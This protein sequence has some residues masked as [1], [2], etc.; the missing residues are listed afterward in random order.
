MAS[1]RDNVC[2]A[3]VV[4]PQDE[5]DVTTRL[6]VDSR[7][8]NTTLHPNPNK[9]TLTLENDVRDV[10]QLR[11]LWAELPSRT[12][13]LV[14]AGRDTVHYRLASDP[15]DTVREAEMQRGD[16]A[17]P[18][19]VATEVENAMNGVADDPATF[20]VAYDAR[21][22]TFSVASKFSFV[23]LCRGE[24]R[25]DH[26]GVRMTGTYREGTVGRLLGMRDEDVSST[27]DGSA[28]T[29]PHSFRAPFRKDFDA[30]R[31][32][33]AVLRIAGATTNVGVSPGL[34]DSFAILKPEDRRA[35]TQML[36]AYVHT[37]DP[38]V[39]RFNRL[40]VSFHAYDGTPYDFQN[41]EHRLEF[42]ITSRKQ[43]KMCPV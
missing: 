10:R 6:V 37:Y 18:A 9:Y 17:T 20:A 41:R 22:D 4:V 14:D 19:D 42:L 32:D 36:R 12:A 40:D 16:Y 15:A 30:A 35:D 34:H 43:R 21:T 13:Y 29:R 3:N 1:N 11:L 25:P 33:Y 5:A 2:S 28:A 27:D 7:D 26:G 39:S 31:D 24:D 23:L 8:R 38:P